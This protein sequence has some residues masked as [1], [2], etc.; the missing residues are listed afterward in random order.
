[1]R[2][3]KAIIFAIL[4]AGVCGALLFILSL[5]RE[6]GEPSVQAAAPS[7]AHKQAAQRRFLTLDDLFAEGRSKSGSGGVP[8]KPD[9][10]ELI[11][12]SQL[13]QRSRLDDALAEVLDSDPQLRKF[14]TLRKKAVRT[15]AE[16]QDYLAMIADAKLIAE[17]REDLIEAFSD[18][19]VDQ[20][21]ELKRLQRIQYLNSA[22]AWKDNPERVKALDAA[23]EIVLA[24]IPAGAS[25]STTGSLLG[26][27]YDLFQLLMV[28][29]PD[30]AKALLAKAQGT[31]SAKILQLAWQT[32]SPHPNDEVS[33]TR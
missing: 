31:R 11:P 25:N 16:Q 23:A 13:E 32:G 15:S 19:G 27:K 22:L 21:D 20:G 4:T 8:D 26:D 10:S 33:P 7:P 30:Q 5:S 9:G 14:Y 12:A 29:D 1:M 2:H 28:S 17:A 24:D 18:G 6:S 3:N